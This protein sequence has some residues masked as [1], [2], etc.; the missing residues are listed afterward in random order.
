MPQVEKLLLEAIEK[1]DAD[2]VHRLLENYDITSSPDTSRQLI[3]AACVARSYM[4][5][6]LLIDHGVFVFLASLPE[7]RNRHIV[8]QFVNLAVQG[9]N[10][11]I[12]AC[13]VRI[14]GIS[15][16]ECCENIVLSD[17]REERLTPLLIAAIHGD[18]PMINYLLEANVDVNKGFTRDG[19]SPLAMA[20][21]HGH[22]MVVETL[23]E[24]GANPE[25]HNNKGED[26]YTL[27][28]AYNHLNILC[29][30]RM[31]HNHE[32]GTTHI[33][34]RAIESTIE[35]LR[36][37]KAHTSYAVR[38]RE[39]VDFSKLQR[40]ISSLKC[41]ITGHNGRLSAVHSS[42]STSSDEVLNSM[43]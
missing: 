16:A 12:L 40:K 27:A 11:N 35:R 22:Y 2:V 26:V 13:V 30:L 8:S 14:T 9:G 42:S 19:N 31:D 10:L 43:H 39:K 6:T 34:G 41:R 20:T 36:Q 28:Q 33:N 21:A 25:H 24:A 37:S 17:G 29:L 4:I 18:M 32:P 1:G 3:A 38:E 7:T 5:F 15:V 23:L